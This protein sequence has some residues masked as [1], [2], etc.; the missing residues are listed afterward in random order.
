MCTGAAPSPV[1]KFAPVHTFASSHRACTGFDALLR[2][3]SLARRFLTIWDPSSPAGLGNLWRKRKDWLW[4]G[5]ALRRSIL[6]RSCVPDAEFKFSRDDVSTPPC[7][8]QQFRFSDHFRVLHGAELDWSAA[9]AG[10]LAAPRLVNLTEYGGHLDSEP[11]IEVR[12]R[13]SLWASDSSTFKAARR[14]LQAALPQ[15]SALRDPRCGA[16]LGYAVSQPSPALQRASRRIWRRAAVGRRVALHVRTLFADNA[17]CFP[18]ELADLARSAAAA[19]AALDGAWGGPACLAHAKAGWRFNLQPTVA[20]RPRA[21]CTARAATASR[22]WPAVTTLARGM[23]PSV[24]A[25]SL[26]RQYPLGRWLECAGVFAGEGGAVFLSTDAPALLELAARAACTHHPQFPYSCGFLRCSAPKL[27]RR[28]RTTGE[29][30]LST[31]WSAGRTAQRTR[32][33]TM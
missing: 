26:G 11:H 31:A 13:Q 28:Q 9:R 24:L 19:G 22:T 21:E 20:S 14:A 6:V 4:L 2:E 8:E 29:F 10:S 25:G 18:R 3:F 30:A 7:R 16:C 23:S 15:P 17:E 1:H 12:F 33:C 5:L 27:S 32:I